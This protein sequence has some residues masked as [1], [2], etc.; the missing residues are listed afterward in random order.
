MYL[1]SFMS[2]YIVNTLVFP[3]FPP[4]DPPLISSTRKGHTPEGVISGQ[5]ATSYSQSTPLNI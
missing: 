3:P 2:A 4:V 1:M 5:S